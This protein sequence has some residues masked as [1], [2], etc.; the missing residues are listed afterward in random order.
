[1]ASATME[2]YV[3]KEDTAAVDIHR[4]FIKFEIFT[5]MMSINLAQQAGD[6][7]ALNHLLHAGGTKI[8]DMYM[9]L[10]DANITY[11]NFKKHVLEQLTLSDSK[12]ANIKFRTCRQGESETLRDFVT[13]LRALATAAKI[14][15]ARVDDEIL[16][17]I[18]TN[19]FSY[20]VRV[21]ALH[22][23]STLSSVLEW[24]TTNEITEKC[25]SEMTRNSDYSSLNQI[26][27]K[28]FGSGEKTCFKCGYEYPHK[29]DLGCPAVNKKCN[30]CGKI[31]HFSRVCRMGKQ[32]NKSI[33]Q[34]S[35]GKIAKKIAKD[36]P[37]INEIKT[38]EL[39]LS[40]MSEEQLT[41]RL[42]KWFQDELEKEEELDAQE[43]NVIS[44]EP[45]PVVVEINQLEE[46]ALKKCPVRDI[47]IG[48]SWISLLIDSGTNL[49]I[50]SWCTYNRLKS[51]PVLSPT[52]VRAFGFNST[53][54][55][56]LKGEFITNVTFRHRVRKT[57]F[58]VLD[59]Q[60][61]D[62][63]GY[64][65][66]LELGII[67]M[68]QNPEKEQRIN[69]VDEVYS[70]GSESSFEDPRVSHPE[71]FTGKVGRLNNFKVH[72]EID[73]NIKPVQQ[74]AYKMPYN[75]HDLTLAKLNKLE[76]MG[77]ISKH[78]QEDGFYSWLSPLHP[79][80]KLNERGEIVDVRLTANN[81]Q[82]NKAIIRQRKHIPSLPELQYDLNG[83]KWFTKLDFMEAFNQLP[84]DDQSRL[85][86]ATATTWGVYIWNAMNMG[87]C[88][89]SEIFQEAMRNLL[90]DLPGVK[91]AMDDVLLATKTREEMEK[92][93]TTVLDRIREHGMTLNPR[94]CQFFKNQI[95][96][97]GMN[98]SEEGIKPKKEK[99]KDLKE[100]E[101]PKDAK[102]VRAFLGL[103][104]YFKTRTPHQSTI[105]KPLR[106]LLI[107]GKRFKWEVD[108]QQA[109]QRI[110]D[111][112]IEEA[113]AHFDCDNKTELIVD[114]SPV[115]CSS[116]LTQLTKEGERKLIKCGSHAFTAAEKNYSH[117]EKE[118]FACAWG[119]EDSHI[120]VYGRPFKLI[121]DALGVQKLLNEDVPRKHIPTRLLRFKSRIS[122]Y[123]CE[124]VHR[125]GNTN[126][127]D[128]LS[129]CLKVDPEIMSG[130]EGQIN[131]EMESS[132]NQLVEEKISSIITL[133]ELIRAT[134]ED[135]LLCKVKEVIRGGI[136]PGQ[137]LGPFKNVFQELCVSEHGVVLR[138]ENIV[139]PVG[140]R[141]NLLS[142][143]HEGHSGRVL[144][145]R[146]LRHIC[147]F[148]GMNKEVDRL[149]KDCL[150]CECTNDNTNREPV[151]PSKLPVKEWH[152]ISIDWTSRTPSNDYLLVLYCDTSREIVAKLSRNMTSQSAIRICKEVFV[153]YGFP[154]VIKSDN[155]PSFI[156]H[157][158]RDF[159]T[160]YKINHVK[161]TPLHPEANGSVERVMKCINKRIRCAAV[162]KS[163]WKKVLESFI[164][165]YR[166]T[167]HSATK[168]TPKALI[169]KS[170]SSS[171]LPMV[172]KKVVQA[173][174]LQQAKW[175]DER[176]KRNMKTYADQ[177]KHTKSFCFKIGEPV[178]HKWERANKYK[179]LFDP[180]A[181]RVTEVKGSRVRV[182][183]QNHSLTRNSSCFKKITEKCYKL[184]MELY[185][186]SDMDQPE[187]K[188]FRIPVQDEEGEGMQ[189][190]PVTQM[191]AGIPSEADQAGAQILLEQS[192]EPLRRKGRRKM[193]RTTFRNPDPVA[194]SPVRDRSRSPIVRRSARNAQ[195]SYTELYRLYP[196]KQFHTVNS[197]I[198]RRS[199]RSK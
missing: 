198:S 41:K 75:L 107:K 71:L 134:Q 9:N 60:A 151:I 162:D 156:S 97:F 169:E 190:P 22:R 23:D 32:P 74:Y 171:L 147:W 129:R 87:L 21:K 6:K 114:A 196:K 4:Y 7:S 56:P 2:A 16:T 181:Y 38:S 117:V 86:T 176:A 5:R 90:G 136:Q 79:V 141:Q 77:V 182:E 140:L 161:I 122:V 124:F 52:K 88:V 121:T 146:H 46:M 14:N 1:M 143:A 20:D 172:I 116:F 157:E 197:L 99:L 57:R 96:F 145:K 49:N 148:P 37:N 67:K 51:R 59:G 80:E 111:I 103:A 36:R 47:K 92:L 154:S 195:V 84:Y 139:I 132:I 174:L 44:E 119:C 98:V 199:G 29:E 40:Q 159:V 25:A 180:Y 193:V 68:E 101:P 8:F 179:P 173:N 62:I 115:G 184:S 189:T 91:V 70:Q 142:F 11:V 31:G 112:V 58:L 104:G 3:Y 63:M 13:R 28:R 125:P 81:I 130:S 185:Q 127:A 106:D 53:K 175:N 138:G 64:S 152:Q 163:N 93:V 135:E 166:E 72:L 160:R 42:E 45:L 186:K 54:I 24:Q 34:N 27:Q 65:T 100:C 170:S 55:I 33:P 188:H 61:S 113:L 48:A 177:I 155:G 183:R 94:K 120:Y 82:L 30:L 191:G 118:A 187:V 150:A 95:D 110:K 158:W 43:V 18:I 105:D 109:Y 102:E 123:N 85:L 78:K 66:A 17:V 178:L 26:S 149:V 76:E 50:L 167:P 12:V 108:E 144:M 131:Q 164:Q 153:K 10:N 39:R 126:I 15:E 137:E 168:V 133:E 69:R 165:R 194:Q 89:A 35:L 128:F 73:P 19:S 83:M 192:Q